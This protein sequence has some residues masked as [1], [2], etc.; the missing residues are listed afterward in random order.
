M[1]SIK[2]ILSQWGVAESALTSFSSHYS[3]DQCNS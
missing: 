3:L 1:A 2:F